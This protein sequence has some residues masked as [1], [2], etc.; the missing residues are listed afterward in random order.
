MRNPY[1]FS[2]VPKMTVVPLVLTLRC[3]HH[4]TT[5][6]PVVLSTTEHHS[7]PHPENKANTGMSWCS[8][9]Q[10]HS[11]R[12]I[13]K[14]GAQATA[15]CDP[16]QHHLS[17]T[18]RGRHGAGKRCETPSEYGRQIWS[19]AVRAR[20]FIKIPLKVLKV[21]PM[22]EPVM[23][24]SPGTGKHLLVRRCSRSV[25]PAWSSSRRACQM[26]IR[27]S[28]NFPGREVTKEGETL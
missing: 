13:G 28:P 5:T 21:S 4:S 8:T 10:V 15:R 2:L 11:T 6:L 7:A 24:R 25:I 27:S 12:G 3:E 16:P 14:C 17:I 18:W 26:T 22:A 19:F 9:D 20:D 1:T 23:S